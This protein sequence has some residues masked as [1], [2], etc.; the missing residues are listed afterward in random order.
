MEDWCYRQ[1][2]NNFGGW[3]INEGSD[4]KFMF[5]FN[6]TTIQL[7]HTYNTEE[8]STDT[9]FEESFADQIFFI[10]FVT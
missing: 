7:E 8:N 4:G 9:I 3:E 10:I 2:E 5:D 6:N 1:L